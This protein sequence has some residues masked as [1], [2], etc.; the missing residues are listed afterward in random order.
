[1]FRGRKLKLKFCE[2]CRL[3]RPMRASHC[4]VCDNCVEHLDHHCPWLGTCSG[5]RN[6]RYFFWFVNLLFAFII[7]SALLLFLHIA[8]T[9]NSLLS[10]GLV[11]MN[12]TV[13]II[14][15]SIFAVYSVV[16][17]FVLV[18]MGSFV[19]LLCVFH[20]CLAKHNWTT[21]EY[22]KRENVALIRGYCHNLCAKLWTKRLP[23]RVKYRAIR[24]MNEAKE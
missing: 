13:F 22:V 2:P 3:Y 11:S 14:I 17:S 18:Q 5:R 19:G 7:I 8:L 1:M 12:S 24:V 4:K 6:Y 10:P 23:Y 16:V 21:R 15:D 9:A 20:Y